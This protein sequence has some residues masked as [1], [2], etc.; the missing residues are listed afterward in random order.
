MRRSSTTR[1]LLSVLVAAV[2]PGG[3]QSQIYEPPIGI[4][5][6]DFGIEETVA[7][8]YGAGYYTHYVDSS[9]PQASDDDNPHGTAARPRMTIPGLL[10]DLDR[11]SV[12]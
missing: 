5:A 11:T 3:A 12:V 8:I 6:P 7:D 2:L 10:T 9:H 4:P 1:V